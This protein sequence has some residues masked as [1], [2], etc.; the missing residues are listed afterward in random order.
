MEALFF[1][2]LSAC[3]FTSS[4][5]SPSRFGEL[6]TPR[7]EKPAPLD[8]QKVLFQVRVSLS[9]SFARTIFRVPQT[10]RKRIGISIVPLRLRG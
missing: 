1:V 9:G 5:R 6:I 3:R 8:I 2:G 10:L 4:E 7:Q